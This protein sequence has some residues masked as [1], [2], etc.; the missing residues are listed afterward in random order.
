[1]RHQRNLGIFPKTNQCHR[2]Q[3]PSAKVDVGERNAVAAKMAVLLCGT[4][5]AW[6]FQPH[7]EFE[8]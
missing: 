4:A 8:V 7:P 5:H 2:R 3:Q 1:M 6:T